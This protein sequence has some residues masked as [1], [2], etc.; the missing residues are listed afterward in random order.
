LIGDIS[1]RD[2]CSVA[3]VLSYSLLSV[4]CLLLVS[5]VGHRA[6]SQLLTIIIY[7]KDANQ[8]AAKQSIDLHTALRA[9]MII[10]DLPA[11]LLGDMRRKSAVSPAS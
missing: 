4:L 6:A 9:R 11:R 5:G 3:W 1:V 7:A 10:V 8:A 2:A